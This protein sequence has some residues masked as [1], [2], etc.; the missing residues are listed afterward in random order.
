MHFPHCPPDRA[1]IGHVPCERHVSHASVGQGQSGGIGI[2]RC[3]MYCLF[4][5]SDASDDITCDK[6]IAVTINL[7][8]LLD[9]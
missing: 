6:T 4:L 2:L 1:G 9:L 7:H 3:F 8:Y 5:V